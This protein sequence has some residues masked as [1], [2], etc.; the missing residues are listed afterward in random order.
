MSAANLFDLSGKVSLV[1]GAGSGIG[2]IFCEAMAEYGSD[3]VCADINETRAKET[4]AI[5]AKNGT[6][7]MAVRAD[8]SNPEDVKALFGKI[9]QEFGRL[10][11]LFNNAGITTKNAR[12]HETSLADWDKVI[13]INLTGV[14]L[15]MQEGIKLMLRQKKGVIVNISSIVGH[16][17]VDP[18]ITAGSNY[19]AAK[20][21]VVGLT[22][23]GAVEYASEGIRVNAILPGWHGGT[24]LGAAKGRNEEQLQDFVKKITERTPMRRR[25][26]AAELKG[27]GIYLA[28][29][30]SG[31]VTGTTFIHDGGWCAW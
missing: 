20:A 13:A 3:V 31:F 19:A 1:T 24:K 5:I 30:A 10:D 11:I 4:V 9:D 18:E 26:E 23:Q 14:F 21:G 25:G 2:R 16:V 17:G 8:V 12:V 15:C 29:D 28:S 7:T 6:K 22:K 27:L